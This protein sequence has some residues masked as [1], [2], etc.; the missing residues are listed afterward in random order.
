MTRF[1]YF[2][3]IPAQAGIQLGPH[4]RGDERS[5]T[6]WNDTWLDR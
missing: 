3:L 6:T 5:G 4:L 2:P 1:D